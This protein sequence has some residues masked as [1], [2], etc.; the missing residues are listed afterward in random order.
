L[1]A[2]TAEQY[3]AMDICQAARDAA[4]ADDLPMDLAARYAAEL[5]CMANHLSIEVIQKLRVLDDVL[6]VMAIQ[7]AIG[8]PCEAQHA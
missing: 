3:R 6:I 7:V 5:L 1:P 4:K 8:A 2:L